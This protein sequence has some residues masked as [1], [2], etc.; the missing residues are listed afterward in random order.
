MT[1]LDNLNRSPLQKLQSEAAEAEVESTNKKT[2][3]SRPSPIGSDTSRSNNPTTPTMTDEDKYIARREES[4]KTSSALPIPL[5]GTKETYVENQKTIQKLQTAFQFDLDAYLKAQKDAGKSEAQALTSAAE[6]LAVR[7]GTLRA[8]NSQVITA[9][10]ALAMLNGTADEQTKNLAANFVKSESDPAFLPHWNDK[11]LKDRAILV[12]GSLSAENDPKKMYE[13]LKFYTEKGRYKEHLDSIDG[14]VR[15]GNDRWNGGAAR[16]SF[17]WCVAAQLGGLPGIIPSNQSNE[18]IS[19]RNDASDIITQA[20]AISK[21]LHGA[22]STRQELAKKYGIK[23]ISK[24]AEWDKFTGTSSIRYSEALYESL[25]K[26]GASNGIVKIIPKDKSEINLGSITDP[27]LRKAVEAYSKLPS[28]KQEDVRDAISLAHTINYLTKGIEASKSN[29]TQRYD[30]FSKKLRE[31]KDSN[32]KGEL[33]RSFDTE[34]SG[35][36]ASKQ[37]AAQLVRDLDPA[38]KSP[39]VTPRTS[40]AQVKAFAKDIGI[41]GFNSNVSILTEELR[42]DLEAKAE[43][44]VLAAQYVH[45]KAHPGNLTPQELKKLKPA[46]IDESKLEVAAAKYKNDK[47]ITNLGELCSPAKLAE[48]MGEKVKAAL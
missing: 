43:T 47:A 18:P 36:V 39:D 7:S 29:F 12:A 26:E 2:D 10:Q 42:R 34:E 25:F 40:L 33:M 23:D 32:S 15:Y 16:D 4:K 38:N 5:E 13:M 24:G 6:V 44:L 19:T 1:G 41:A 46:G 27:N 37:L 45:L 22:E 8:F 20:G 9:D 48:V 11:N 14:T 3:A 35:E 17:Y 21:A 30:Q 28:E 31:S